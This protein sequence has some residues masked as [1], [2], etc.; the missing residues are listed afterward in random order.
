M[1]SPLNVSRETIDRLKIYEALLLKWQ[2]HLNLVSKTTLSDLR[3]RHFLD[4]AQ[5]FSEVPNKNAVVCD[6]GS[7]AGFP[8]AVLAIMGCE[9]VTLIE[10]DKKKCTF[11][12]NVSRET[13][14]RF[15]VFEGDV[16]EFDKKADIVTSRALAPLKDLLRLAEP[17]IKPTTVCLFL[18]GNSVKDELKDIPLGMEMTSLKKQSISSKEGRVLILKNIFYPVKKTI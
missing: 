15:S 5:L 8:G 17:L 1:L 4:S 3:Q 2:P 14:V 16:K 10:R 13:N 7:G 6:L 9:N 11:L 12:R 18:K